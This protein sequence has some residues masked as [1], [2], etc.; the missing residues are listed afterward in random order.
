MQ[1]IKIDLGNEELSHIKVSKDHKIYI[2]SFLNLFFFSIKIDSYKNKKIIAKSLMIYDFS[3]KFDSK[4]AS[5]KPIN[6]CIISD[7]NSEIYLIN[8]TSISVWS[9]MTGTQTRRFEN[10]VDSKILSVTLD[11]FQKVIF[12]GLENG[13]IK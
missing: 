1:T 13:N 2:L 9:L 12:L 11:A 10:I 6:L 3:K 8:D 7:I 4:K 5:D